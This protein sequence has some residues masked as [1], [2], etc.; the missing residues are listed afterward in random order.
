MSD[1][2]FVDTNIFVYADDSAAKAK[3]PLVR[4]SPT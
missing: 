4:C 3:R 1:R 2:I